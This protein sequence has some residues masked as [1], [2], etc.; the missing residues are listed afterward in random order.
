M[1]LF[2]LSLSLSHNDTTPWTP[3]DGGVLV[4]SAIDGHSG[5]VSGGYS[6]ETV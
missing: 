6:S 3:G 1:S 2:L 5:L 4:P